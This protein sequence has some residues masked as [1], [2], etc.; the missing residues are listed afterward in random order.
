MLHI[1]NHLC[2]SVLDSP[3][4]FPVLLELRGPELDAIFQMQSHWGRVEGENLS[5]PTK[6]SPSNT[7]Q[8]AIGLLGLKGMVL[9]QGGPAVHQHP[10]VLFPYAALQQVSP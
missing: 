1:L 4:Q 3:K 2:G 10:Q 5:Q 7:P 8:D 6:L 9:A